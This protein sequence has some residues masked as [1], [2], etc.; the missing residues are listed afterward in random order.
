MIRSITP[1]PVRAEELEAGVEADG[2][3]SALAGWQIAEPFSRDEPVPPDVGREMLAMALGLDERAFHQLSDAEI[4]TALQRMR[5]LILQFE[6]VAA[7]AATDELTGVLRRG[8]GITALQREID[9]ERRKPSRGNV[10]VFVDVDG[11]K[12]VNDTEGHA[13]GDRLIVDVVDAIRER[14]R[15]YDLLFRYGGDEFVFVLVDI[16]LQQAHRTVDEIRSDITRRSDGS[17]VSTGVVQ[18]AAQDTAET[19]VARADQAL[20]RVRRRTRR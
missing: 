3:L 9:R 16:G 13:A 6:R 20:Y 8:P 17:T 15:S 4:D 18:V 19:A 7:K 12:R 11:L 14:I 5:A 1:M 2:A 10:V